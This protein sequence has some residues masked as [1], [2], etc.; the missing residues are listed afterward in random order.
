MKNIYIDESGSM[1]KRIQNN[2]FFIVSLVV[3][4]NATEL[5]K[6]YKRFVSKNIKNLEV[7]D[8]S[9]S[10]RRYKRNQKN[11]RGKMFSDSKF[12]ELKGSHFTK[13]I[14]QDFIDFFSR[15][16][17][18]SLYYIRIN[19]YELNERNIRFKARTF[20]LSIRL[21]IG[22]FMQ[23][24]LME[25]S[26]Y[27]LHLDE[28][29]EKISNLHFLQ[30]YLNTELYLREKINSEFE[31]EYLE[32]K[33]NKFIQIADV[34]SNLLYSHYKTDSYENELKLLEDRGILKGIYDFPPRLK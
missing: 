33:N 31:V 13:K 23:E 7:A 14:K 8:K 11:T 22:S 10:R 16:N 30:N 29:N 2:Q 24:G 26:N 32:S 3:I 12:R 6:V 19:N 20:N 4:N 5:K 1:N 15:K 25:E 34:F 17:H 9:K 18:L 21:A 28:R 27:F